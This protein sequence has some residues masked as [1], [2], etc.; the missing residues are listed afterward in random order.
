MENFQDLLPCSFRE[1][2]VSKHLYYPLMFNLKYRILENN[3]LRPYKKQYPG[4][5]IA[6]NQQYPIFEASQFFHRL[7]FLYY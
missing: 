4:I 1:M 2:I 5:S 7:L 3:N 6:L